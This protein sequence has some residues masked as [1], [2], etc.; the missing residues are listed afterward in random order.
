MYIVEDVVVV[1]HQ[2]TLV[3]QY[4]IGLLLVRQH[5][6]ITDGTSRHHRRRGETSPVVLIRSLYCADR[7]VWI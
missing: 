1:Q 3:R 4:I 6:I 5:D 2:A 7:L